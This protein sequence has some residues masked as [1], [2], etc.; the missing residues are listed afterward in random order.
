MGG[1]TPATGGAAFPTVKR[2]YGFNFA[3]DF[4]RLGRIQYPAECIAIADSGTP[5]PDMG[6]ACCAPGYLAA[7]P[8]SG[9]C[10]TNAPWGHVSFRHNEGT[11]VG[12]VDGHAKWVKMNAAVFGN[13]GSSR[14]WQPGG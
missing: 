5:D 8:R 3:I 12:F 13:N 2:S 14:W 4:T 6:T 10:A 9:C 7:A 1:Q 11:N